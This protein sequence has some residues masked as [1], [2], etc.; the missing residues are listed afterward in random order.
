MHITGSANLAA[1]HLKIA[2]ELGVDISKDL[3]AAIEDKLQ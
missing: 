3:L 1:E 2:E